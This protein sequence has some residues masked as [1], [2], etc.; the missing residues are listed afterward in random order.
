MNRTLRLTAATL[1]ALLLLPVLGACSALDDLTGRDEEGGGEGTD[2]ADREDAMLDYAQCM[3]EHGVP[4]EDPT[5]D[6]GLLI[7]ADGSVDEETLK[8]AE[9]ACGD[10]LEDVMGEDGPGEMPAEQKEAMLAMAQCMRDRGWD[11]PDPQF[12][13]GRVTQ[14]LDGRVDPEDPAFQ[15]D[16]EECAQESGVEMP[17]REGGS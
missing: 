2:A 14:R 9:E 3:R 15:R 13:G 10:L 12:D 5:G 16:S 1:L 11:M 8:A 4:M 7:K 17:R 6:R